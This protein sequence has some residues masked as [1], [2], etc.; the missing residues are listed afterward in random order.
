MAFFMVTDCLDLLYKIMLRY[1]LFL[2]PTDNIIACES[3][4]QEKNRT[5]ILLPQLHV[6]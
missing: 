1:T 2:Y 3:E 5:K 6:I 4:L